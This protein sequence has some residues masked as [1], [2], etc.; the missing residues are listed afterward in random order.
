MH[1]IPAAILL[2]DPSKFCGRRSQWVRMSGSK[3]MV[4]DGLAEPPAEVL[5]PD[6][7]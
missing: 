3:R 4:F 1:Y 2:G 7:P 6:P 5:L